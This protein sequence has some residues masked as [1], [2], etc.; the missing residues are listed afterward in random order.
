[1]IMRKNFSLSFAFV[2]HQAQAF[3]KY[4]LKTE[5]GE[6]MKSDDQTDRE[7]NLFVKSGLGAWFFELPPPQSVD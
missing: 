4:G 2:G 7:R 1:M 5:T 3:S 6:N